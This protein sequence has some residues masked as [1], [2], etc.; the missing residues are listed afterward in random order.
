MGTPAVNIGTRQAGRERG[1]NIVYVPHDRRAIAD[2][3]KRQVAHGR[4]TPD[5]LYGDGSAGTRI[6]DILSR[7][8]LH[9]QKRI[10]Y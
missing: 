4:H 10:Q 3:I 1:P 6:A 7:A 9:V 2:A 5:H 8:P